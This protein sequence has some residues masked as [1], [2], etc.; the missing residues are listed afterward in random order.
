MLTAVDRFVALLGLGV[1][2]SSL[3]KAA[4]ADNPQLC[5]ELWRT[6]RALVATVQR[7]CT[8]TG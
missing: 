4:N 6:V 5:G 7:G 2:L 8:T 3:W 1:S